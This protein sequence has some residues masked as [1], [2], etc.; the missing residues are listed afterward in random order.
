MQGNAIFSIIQTTQLRV[1]RARMLAWR[2][3]VFFY[4]IPVSLCREVEQRDTRGLG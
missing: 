2:D 1:L 4:L 3:K